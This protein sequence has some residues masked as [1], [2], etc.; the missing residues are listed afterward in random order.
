MGKGSEAAKKAQEVM[1]EKHRAKKVYGRQGEPQRQL[2]VIYLH[3]L[4][5]KFT[6]RELGSHGRTK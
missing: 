4:I 3:L 2:Q 5:L 1:S 6:S